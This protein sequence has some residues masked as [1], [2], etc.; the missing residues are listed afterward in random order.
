MMTP[1][2]VDNSLLGKEKRFSRLSVIDSINTTA[3]VLFEAAKTK[4]T[5]P[6]FPNLM[7]VLSGRL[8]TGLGL[9]FI[10]CTNLLSTSGFD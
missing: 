2:P 6:K 7:G 4:S 1:D 3:G 9:W 8:E 10:S 5:W